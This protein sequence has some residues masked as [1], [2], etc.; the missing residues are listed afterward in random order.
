MLQLAA[1][2]QPEFLRRSFDRGVFL[3]LSPQTREESSC[4]RGR[5][6]DVWKAL[7]RVSPASDV[8]MNAFGRPC[9]SAIWKAPVVEVQRCVES[10]VEQACIDREKAIQQK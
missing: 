5:L 6:V 3:S 8:L 10:A 4:F 7:S 2:T 1:A 9:V